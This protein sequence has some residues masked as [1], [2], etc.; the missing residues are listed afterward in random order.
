MGKWVYSST[1]PNTFTG[2]LPLPCMP[3]LPKSD[4]SQYLGFM[5]A[6]IHFLCHVYD[7]ESKSRDYQLI[8][9]FKYSL[10]FNNPVHFFGMK[11]AVACSCYG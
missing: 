5:Y 10:F 4:K 9:I 3:S 7:K 6:L 2:A 8:I 1:S 11:K